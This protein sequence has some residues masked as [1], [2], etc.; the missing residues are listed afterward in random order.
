MVISGIAGSG[1]EEEKMDKITCSWLEA[2]HFATINLLVL[3]CLS[4][5]G[6]LRYWPSNFMDQLV[7]DDA[8]DEFYSCATLNV[9]V[10]GHYFTY[11][12]VSYF[13]T[14]STLEF[15]LPSPPQVS[16]HI[17]TFGSEQI[18]FCIFEY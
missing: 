14:W 4:D 5:H 16:C 7:N 3:P 1:N 12:I 6:T 10:F 2:L 9:Q 8:L 18:Y 13:H 15:P 17:V 11:T